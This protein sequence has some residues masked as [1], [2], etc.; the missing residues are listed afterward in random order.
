M[1]HC[2]V[3]LKDIMFTSTILQFK[4]KL[5]HWT[6]KKKI[7]CI[8][9]FILAAPGLSCDTRALSCSMQDR[10]PNQGSTPGPLHK[11]C[12][13]LL[14]GPPGKHW[15]FFICVVCCATIMFPSSHFL[16]LFSSVLHWRVSP[17]AYSPLLA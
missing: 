6:L 11:E 17:L 15:T 7:L 10:V 2:V 1:N 13:V 9:L 3:H 12:R 8:N 16:G 14:T 5:I 4:K